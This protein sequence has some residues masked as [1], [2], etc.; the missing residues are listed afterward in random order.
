MAQRPLII[1]ALTAL[2]GV[3]VG[4]RRVVPAI[5]DVASDKDFFGPPFPADYPNDKNPP[6]SEMSGGERPY[7]DIQA[8]HTFDY[9]F[10]KD[11]KNDN[12]EW[13]TQND[14]DKARKK[15]TK[16][17]SE[18]EKAVADAKKKFDDVTGADKAAKKAEDALDDAMKDWG[19]ADSEDKESKAEADAAAAARKKK[20]EEEAKKAADEDKN[21]K[22]DLLRKLNEAKRNYAKEKADF[23]ECTKQLEEVKKLL[24]QA[25]ANYDAVYGKNGTN[26]LA[27]VGGE[28]L[29]HGG[30]LKEEKNKVFAATAKREWAANKMEAAK[31]VHEAAQKVLAK[32]RAAEAKTAKAMKKEVADQENAEQTLEKAGE[33]LRSVRGL[34]PLHPAPATLAV[35]SAASIQGGVALA[36]LLLVVAVSLF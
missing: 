32:A 36:S 11:S 29:L 19:L 2:V 10:V 31:K 4:H 13:K 33:H 22:D 5:K 21:E 8:S 3:A 30:W 23:E 26:P 27:A 7:P 35:K 25:Q 15:A 28:W 12:G 20:E 1:I 6:A 18:A 24:D 16:E 14:Y 34:P 17:A 9:D